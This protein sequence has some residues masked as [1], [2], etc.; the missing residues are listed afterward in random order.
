MGKNFYRDS[1]LAGSE[2]VPR[3]LWNEYCREIAE[4][5]RPILGRLANHNALVK[6]MRAKAASS[7]SVIFKP[8]KGP[9]LGETEMLSTPQPIM[10]QAMA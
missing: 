1:Q 5:K 7:E 3:S 10:A 9:L 4:W 2:V 6:H 8:S